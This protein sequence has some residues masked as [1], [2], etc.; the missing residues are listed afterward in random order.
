MHQD[1]IRDIRRRCRLSMNGIVSASMREKGLTYKLNF[2]LTIQQIKDIAI[3][4]QPEAALAGNLWKEEVRELKIMATMLYPATEFTQET[5]HKWVDE[6]T[7]Q[8][9][10]EQLCLNLLQG[11]P[12]APGLAEEWSNNSDAEKRITGYWLLSRLFLT[13]K[14]DKAE[15]TTFSFIVE[16][17]V[18]ENIFLRNAALLALKHIGR[19]SEEGAERILNNFAAYKDDSNPVKQEA[20]NSLHFEFDYYFGD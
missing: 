9:I 12:F 17:A 5:A 11:L 10:R 7:T 16:D 13:K 4:Y 3:Q 6:I 14:A 15:L 1:I 18:S 2:G 19:Q 20:Y 8:E